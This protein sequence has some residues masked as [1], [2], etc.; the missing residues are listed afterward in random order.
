VYLGTIQ[1]EKISVNL[2]S[3]G[4]SILNAISKETRSIEILC[5]AGRSISRIRFFYVL[6][7]T[8]FIRIVLICICIRICNTV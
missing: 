3:G 1:V 8:A 7:K 6:T 2:V 4:N 5:S